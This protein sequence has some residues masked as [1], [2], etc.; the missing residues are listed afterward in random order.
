[1]LFA[2]YFIVFGSCGKSCSAGFGDDPL[3]VLTQVVG[4]ITVAFIEESDRGCLVLLLVGLDPCLCPTVQ[5]LIVSPAA[6]LLISSKNTF[7]LILS[8]LFLALR[9]ATLFAVPPVCGSF[10]C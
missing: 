4:T 3:K 8:T 10:K 2:T 6:L 9:T 5:F 1:V 7:Q